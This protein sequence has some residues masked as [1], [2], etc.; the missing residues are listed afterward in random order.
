MKT[1]YHLAIESDSNNHI[2]LI[3]Y[4]NIDTLPPDIIRYLGKY[5]TTQRELKSNKDAWLKEFNRINNMNFKK[6]SIRFM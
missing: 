2:K 1:E 6:V 3:A 5:T 4:T